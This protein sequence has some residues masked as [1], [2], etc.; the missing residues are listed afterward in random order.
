M[1]D[2]D[3]LFH[4]QSLGKGPSNDGAAGEIMLQRLSNMSDAEWNQE[5]EYLPES[6][7][8][9]DH[10]YFHGAALGDLI[11]LSDMLP[12]LMFGVVKINQRNKHQQRWI[13][14]ES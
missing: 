4:E 12:A 14:L 3:H 5:L 2:C 7:M 6:G 10:G 8:D 9:D 1:S 11:K 13:R